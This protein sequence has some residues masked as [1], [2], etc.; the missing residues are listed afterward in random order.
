L[1]CTGRLGSLNRLGGLELGTVGVESEVPV[2]GVMG[3]NEGVA[4]GVR[5][6]DLLSDGCGDTSGQWD[7]GRCRGNTSGCGCRC[8]FCGFGFSSDFGIEG[9]RI[10]ASGLN[11]ISF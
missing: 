10:L 7:A 11:M 2:G 4:V 6:L 3:V 5:L 1:G 8:G 9:S